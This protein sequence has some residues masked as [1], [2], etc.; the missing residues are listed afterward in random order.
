ME[1]KSTLE[2]GDAESQGFWN[3]YTKKLA[4]CASLDE[5]LEDITPTCDAM[6]VQLED[7]ACFHDGE[8]RAR[9]KNFGKSLDEAGRL[10]RIAIHGRDDRAHYNKYVKT[11]D[12]NGQK[13]SAPFCPDFNDERLR[14]EH[15]DSNKFMDNQT[16][17]DLRHSDGTA[18]TRENI[19]GGIC[20]LEYDRKR[21]VE[22]LHIVMC[23][24]TKVNEHVT[25]SIETGEDCITETS[26]PDQVGREID[27]CHAIANDGA[28]VDV[29]D[30]TYTYNS[31]ELDI[32][33][34]K[35]PLP[36][37]PPRPKDT[38]C[39]REFVQ[40]EQDTLMS[41]A[42]PKMCLAATEEARPKAGGVDHCD[43]NRP[44][45]ADFNY[46]EIE[47]VCMLHQSDL[48]PGQQ[49]AD[50]FMCATGG[51][52]IDA[53]GRCNGLANCRDGSDE[54]NCLEGEADLPM[55][56]GA[57]S[58]LAVMATSGRHSEVVDKIA[59]GAPVYFDRQG[60]KD[61]AENP[62][63]YNYIAGKRVQ[64]HRP[65]G[66][67]NVGSE[68]LS[69]DPKLEKLKWVKYSND[70]KF[71]PRDHVMLK[72]SVPSPT[73]VYVNVVEKAG[74]STA[75]NGWTPAG[76]KEEASKGVVFKSHF[77]VNG[78]DKTTWGNALRVEH[79][80][81]GTAT[82]TEEFKGKVYSKVFPAGEIMLRG[83]GGK[84]G[85]YLVFLEDLKSQCFDGAYSPW[86]LPP[87]KP[88]PVQ[89]EMPMD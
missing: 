55:V 88:E 16:T 87:N 35:Q 84:D 18:V 57:G 27:Q 5:S 56:C 63:S 37:I 34:G 74:S 42:A 21:E 51:N 12:E 39:T 62:A 46:H 22:T 36:K 80:Q 38:P 30:A 29:Q 44:E 82:I 32:D 10:Y 4:E 85:S 58:P 7:D 40:F 6:Q 45:P 47:Y 28:T 61:G 52:C 68:V 20:R 86:A 31:G 49:D 23:L 70:D 78:D 11:V 75:H 64:A 26:N 73:R 69:V 33:Y 71:T 48:Q 81:D 72:V 13:F 1:A 41:C 43:A 66:N 8:V 19:E 15:W 25:M 17:T 67:D 77:T 53:I 2:G 60:A 14:G 54:Q 89:P 50:T 59:K 9:R 24:L 76:W 83:N 3:D 79:F 65:A